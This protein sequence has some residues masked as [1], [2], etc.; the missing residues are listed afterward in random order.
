MNAA[1]NAPQGALAGTPVRRTERGWPGHFILGDECDFRRNTLLERGDTR[2]VVSTVGQLK[3]SRRS[4]ETRYQQV[5]SGRYYETMA[6][7]A[8]LNCPY[9]DADVC[10]EISFRAPSA[11]DAPGQDNE[12]NAMHDLAVQ[13]VQSRL[14]RGELSDL[15]LFN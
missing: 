4:T 3:P 6:F 13:E 11:I 12:A 7:H 14:E 10:R 15:R 9:H 2:I 8:M 1:L 5:G